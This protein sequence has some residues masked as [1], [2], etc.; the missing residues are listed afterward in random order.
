MNL[1]MTLYIIVLFIALTPGV[2]LR[3]PAKG[4]LLTVAIVHGIVFALVYYFTHRI[5]YQISE[6]FANP[7]KL[8]LR[9]PQG[10]VNDN[11]KCLPPPP[12]RQ[13]GDIRVGGKCVA[14]KKGPSFSGSI[15]RPPAGEKK[16]GRINKPRQE[17][18]N[19]DPT[20]TQRVVF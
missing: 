12:C 5:V 10:Y 8:K 13:K 2:L 20:R 7:P 16:D 18:P 1:F 6:G 14:N 9:C 3:L 4:P 15:F 11:G 19:A 17:N